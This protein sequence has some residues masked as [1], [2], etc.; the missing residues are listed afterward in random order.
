LGVGVGVGVGDVVDGG[1]TG[2]AKASEPHTVFFR[3]DFEARD[4]LS[5]DKNVLFM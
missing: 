2:A 3:H 4:T 1:G 5:M